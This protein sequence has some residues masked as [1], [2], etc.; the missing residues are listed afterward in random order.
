EQF[1]VA[2]EEDDDAQRQAMVAALVEEIRSWDETLTVHDGQDYTPLRNHAL[3]FLAEDELVEL[4]DELVA[5]RQRS[6]A[7]GIAGFGD[8]PIDPDAVT[9]E[10]DEWEV[11]FAG[12]DTGPDTGSDTEPPDPAKLDPTNPD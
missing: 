10:G 7:R 3:Y 12:P 5:E 9:V 6:I 8:G 4:R 1:I 11:D 2:V